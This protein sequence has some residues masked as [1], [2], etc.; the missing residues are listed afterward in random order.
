MLMNRHFIFRDIA[1]RDV[2]PEGW[3]RGYLETQARG[4]TGNMAAAGYP[5]DT[6]GWGGGA[7]VMHKTGDG[8]WPYEQTG[9][10]T[11]GAL[12]CAHLLRDQHLLAKAVQPVEFTLKH[13]GKNGFLGVK[14]LARPGLMNQWVHAVFFRAIMAHHSATGQRR[15]VE[16]MRRHFH[17]K[18]SDYTHSREICCIEAMLYT[19]EHTG[20]AALLALA[21]RAYAGFCK[22]FPNHDTALTNQL[23]DKRATAHGVTYNEMGKI[24][25]ILYLHTGN[26]Q[27]L[28]AAQN[29]WAKMDRDQMLVD[30]I[31]SSSE[32]LRGK[33]P[34]DSHETCVIA[35][36]TWS[37][38]YLLLATGD[39]AYADKIERACFNAAPGAIRKDFKAL[40]YFSC[41]NQVV[42]DHSSNHN[43]F[44]RGL[45]W[46]SF[47]PNPGTECCPGQVNR[48]MPNFAARQWLR[49]GSGGVVAALYGPSRYTGKLGRSQEEV[50]IVEET[51]YPFSE[52]IEF[53][54]R[55]ARPVRFPFLLRIP[56][57]CAA[58]MLTLNGA[59]V[60][61]SCKPGSFVTL[62]REFA[63]NDRLSLLLPMQLKLTRWPGGGVAVE[64]GPLVYSLSIKEDW[65]H[66]PAEERQS[67]EFPAWDLYAASP[68]NY[69]LC[70]D[71]ANLEQTVEIVR[72]PPHGN[73][74]TLDGAPL[75]L[76]VPARRVKGWNVLR[77]KMVKTTQWD[78]K[79]NAQVLVPLKG[80]FR[81][82]PPL[83][84]PETLPERLAETVETIRL[85]PY[86]CTQ[87]RITIFPQ[88][89]RVADCRPA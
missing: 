7:R 34:L 89:P 81:L 38:G 48:I 66:D 26:R 1:L 46:M 28:K 19:Y 33:D 36:Y 84:A 75:E 24:P 41:P 6:A 40:Q 61:L 29:A 16:A 10:W 27:Y 63:P 54:I 72:N 14:F 60:K 2:Q 52:Q 71:E 62:D 73:P 83:P 18:T 25:A 82:T 44:S 77:R 21:K 53:S 57:W 70:V 43:E 32:H 30:G 58:P 31:P 47:R 12:R 78:A 69:A 15:F 35:D 3:V 68:W 23:S 88:A 13:A 22:K 39:A 4:L 45:K 8:W 67:Q 86:G 56:H 80:D 51:T 11:D 59:P 17:S 49:T 87:L 20:D 9:Y 42:A 37:A 50:T 85:V 74:W 5:F 65:R 55:C 76:R 64:R 79:A